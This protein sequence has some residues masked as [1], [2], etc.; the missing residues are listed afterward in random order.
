MKKICTGLIVLG[1]IL[2]VVGII[3]SAYQLTQK[4]ETKETI[5]DNINVYLSSSEIILKYK[6]VVTEKSDVVDPYYGEDTNFVWIVLDDSSAL[7]SYFLKNEVESINVGDTVILTAHINHGEW[8]SHNIEKYSAV[9]VITGYIIS[10]IGAILV[11]VALFIYRK[12][13]IITKPENNILGTIK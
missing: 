4:Y 3:A 11:I 1:V 12:D 6:G 2:L 13:E 7:S 9:I 5:L 10:I 8:V